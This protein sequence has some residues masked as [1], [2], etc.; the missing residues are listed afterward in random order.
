MASQTNLISEEKKPSYYSNWVVLLIVPLTPLDSQSCRNK[1]PQ[2][3]WLKTTEILFSHSSEGQSQKS[4]C[5]QGP[6]SSEGSQEDSLLAFSN[7]GGSWSSLVC[8]SLPLVSASIFTWPSSLGV[9]V[10]SFC[11]SNNDTWFRAQLNPGW[12]HLEIL[13]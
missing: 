7:S 1:W 2:I 11:V 9:S 13:I 4:R 10:F 12:P 6:A 3:R 8:G 5:W